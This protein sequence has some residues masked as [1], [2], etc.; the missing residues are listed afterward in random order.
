MARGKK[1]SQKKK[2]K[3]NIASGVAH[4]KSTFNN[5]II[6]ITDFNGNTVSWSSSGHMG[7][8]GARKSTP[9]AA[10][11]TAESVAKKAMDNGLRTCVFRW[12]WYGWTGKKGSWISGRIARPVQTL[13]VNLSCPGIRHYTYWK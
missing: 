12:T 11:V 1:A 6:T 7:F 10:Q 8:K 5:T 13:P 3:K 9:F 2:E 4:I